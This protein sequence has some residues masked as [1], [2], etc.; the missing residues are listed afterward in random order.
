MLHLVKTWSGTLL[1]LVLVVTVGVAYLDAHYTDLTWERPASY[2]WGMCWHVL[3][4][5][6]LI[7]MVVTAAKTD[8]RAPILLLSFTY[9]KALFF[10]VYASLALFSAGQVWPETFGWFGNDWIFALFIGTT[11]ASSAVNFV[12]LFGWRGGW[13]EESADPVPFRPIWKKFRRRK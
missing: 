5:Y 10:L 4:E 11:M 7:K 12:L 3:G 2:L 8:K 9:Q 6:V 1:P 13:L